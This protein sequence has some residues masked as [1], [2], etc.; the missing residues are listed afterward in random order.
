MQKPTM[1]VMAPYTTVSGY[2]AHS[3]DIIQA[4]MESERYNLY[5]VPMNW[6]N[7]PQ[8]ALKESNP[9]HKKMLDLTLDKQ[10]EGKPDYFVHISIPLEFRPFGVRNIGITAGM[11]TD[12][13]AVE[14]IEKANAM[15]V[16]IVPS[17]HSKNAHNET[18][19]PIQPRPDQP[20]LGEF[21]N[22]KPIEVLFEGVDLNIYKPL[23]EGPNRSNVLAPIYDMPEEFAFL[24]TGHWM[25]GGFREGRKDTDGLIYN[26]INTFNYKK[27][28]VAL[29]LKTTMGN[30]SRL[31]RQ[32]LLRKIDQIRDMFPD[33]DQQP[34][35][36]LV[37]GNLTDAEINEL[38]NIP[39]I[40]AMVSLTH[41]EGY[42][43]PL[44]EFSAATGKPVFA[45]FWSGHVDFLFEGANDLLFDYELAQVPKSA[46]WDKVIVAD[47]KWANVKDSDVSQKLTK[48]F[49]KYEDMLPIAKKV[50]QHIIT[51]K[52]LPL[53]KDKLIQILDKYAPP[54]KTDLAL[55]KLDRGG[56]LDLSKLKGFKKS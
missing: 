39:K 33:R 1:V 16:M 40:K 50:Q 44:A 29:V 12:K 15:D 27:G 26:F 18:V 53:M 30:F 21:R 36:Y 54:M 56:S 34:N 8:N 31:D 5:L 17:E 24:Y 45:P 20:P 2:G 6:G 51:Y 55:P 14:W 23:E 10:F 28:E 3:R 47:S 19:V 11:E 52:T 41:G 48:C 22:Q 46:V 13:V 7:T 38:Y 35:I 4:L 32:A 49:Y 37:H 42:G 25:D 43:R 9:V